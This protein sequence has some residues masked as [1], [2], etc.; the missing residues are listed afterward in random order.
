MSEHNHE[1]VTTSKNLVWSIGINTIIVVFEIIFGLISRSFALITDALHNVTDIGSMTL[2]LWGEKLADKPQT[3]TKTYGYK[4]AEVI[5]AFINGGVLLAIVGFVLVE[6]A[7]RIFK[8]EPVSGLTMMIVSG[9]ALLGNGLA[10]YLLQKGSGKNLNLK[11]AWLHSMQDALFSLGVVVSAAIIY[12][13]GWSWLDPIA[14]IIISVFLLKEIFSILFEAVDMMLDSVPK[15]VNFSDVKASLAAIPGVIEIDDLHI[16]QTGS[17]NRF[18]SAH[19][20]ISED[21]KSGRIK[22]LAQVAEI[23]KEKYNIHHATI[24]IVSEEEIKKVNL[25]CEHCN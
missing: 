15:D 1:H 20:I 9:V 25:E 23:A 10:T 24:Q 17:E 12:F 7:I 2:S 3:E 13:T 8:P 22:L 5:I 4:R 11:S 14:S 6:A 21:V 16:W 19:L 18:L